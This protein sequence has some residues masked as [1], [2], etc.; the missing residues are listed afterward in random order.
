MERRLAAILASGVVG[1][2]RAKQRYFQLTDITRFPVG[3][4]TT[5]VTGGLSVFSAR[6]NNLTR[7]GGQYDA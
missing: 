6:R 3:F 5:M 1:Y 4:F 2:S 7:S